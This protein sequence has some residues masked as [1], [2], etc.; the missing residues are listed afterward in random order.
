ML[1]RPSKN[2]D[3]FIDGAPAQKQTTPAKRGPGR[4]PSGRAKR[5]ARAVVFL[6]PAHAERVAERAREIGV[7][8]SALIAMALDRFFRAD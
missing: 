1:K 8:Q 5:D 4:P 3:A 6:T 2:A 7:T